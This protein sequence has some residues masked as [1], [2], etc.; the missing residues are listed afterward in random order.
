MAVLDE[1][2]VERERERVQRAIVHLSKGDY[3]RLQ[4][5][6]RVAK[7]DYRDVLF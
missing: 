4:H 7:W 6:T 3:G 5:F 1:Y 2:G